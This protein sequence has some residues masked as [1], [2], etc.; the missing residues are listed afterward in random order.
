MLVVLVAG[1]YVAGYAVAGDKVPRGTTVA[2]VDIGGLA[3]GDARSTL[4][5]ALAERERTPVE[6][7]LG[8]RTS[9][10][11]PAEAGLSFDHAATVAATDAGS[12]WSPTRLWGWYVGDESVEP[13]VRVDEERLAEAVAQLQ[14]D[15]GDEP[16]DG[17][18]RLQGTRVVVDDPV[19]G[20][21]IDLDVAREALVDALVGGGTA[22]LAITELEPEIGTDEVEAAVSDLAEPA[23]AAPVR[24]RFG[25]STVRLR[26]RQYAGA[27][28]FEPRDGALELVVD[29]AAVVELVEGA[30]AGAGEPVDARIELVDGKPKVIKAKPGISFQPADVVAAFEQVV[31]APDGERTADVEGTV[32]QPEFT[33][34]D[35]RALGVKRRVSTFV[36]EFPYAEYRNTNIGRAAEIV[37]GTLLMPGEVFSLN[38]IVGERTAENG[39]AIGTII[40]NGIFV[41]DYGG[42]VSQ[43]ATTTFNAA[44]YAGLKDIEH[45]PHSV[46]I[47]RYPEGREATVAWPTV[48]LRFQNDTDHGILIG[49]EFV[50]STPSSA[51]S[52]R[53]SMYST[54]VWDIDDETSERYAYVSP[55]TR[56]LDTPNCVPNTGYSGFQV[57]VT[58][59]FRRHGEAEVVKRETFHTDYIASDTVIC[60]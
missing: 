22:E 42:G 45:K 26:P 46:F 25:G 15:V 29:D 53:V 55:G 39:F 38:D 27:L 24:L 41:E 57:D 37:D 32:E 14:G 35:A 34:K 23:L 1:L 49:T 5:D 17:A 47:D 58:R 54:K 56:R 43:M 4:D 60:R 2:G 6:V 16:V 9:T 31:T 3:P 10:L 18:V 33:T 28:S 59:I 30:T 52:V 21:G 11:D 7:R 51:G 19:P 36:T 44:F 20:R 13:V 12:S 48:D 8:D 40:Q 50:D